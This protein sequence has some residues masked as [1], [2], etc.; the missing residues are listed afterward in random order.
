MMN[1][2]EISM[3]KNKRRIT[4]LA[5]ILMSTTGLNFSSYA[6]TL[7]ERNDKIELSYYYDGNKRI[8]PAGNSGFVVVYTNSIMSNKQND[9]LCGI[10]EDDAISQLEEEAAMF[11]IKIDIIKT[12][13]L[14][15]SN[16]KE[17]K[18][19]KKYSA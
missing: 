4:Q 17:I 10:T 8:C 6:N 11:E 13:R 18:S 7:C 9:F 14:K 12:S 3:L 19:C 2:R 16:A 5:L 15:S 1:N